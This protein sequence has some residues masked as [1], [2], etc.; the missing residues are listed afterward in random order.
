MKRP[1][2]IPF[3]SYGAVKH[4]SSAWGDC[5]V[6]TMASH[7]AEIMATLGCVLQRSKAKPPVSLPHLLAASKIIIVRNSFQVWTSTLEKDGEE[8]SS[9]CPP[10]WWCLFLILLVWKER[11]A[12]VGLERCYSCPSRPLDG[13]VCGEGCTKALSVPLLL[14]EMGPGLGGAG[15]GGCSFLGSC[16]FLET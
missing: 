1:D 15:A 10:H 2:I 13:A 6:F 7:C 16:F 3:K 9:F 8:P 11:G 12:L 5:L 14:P 4:N